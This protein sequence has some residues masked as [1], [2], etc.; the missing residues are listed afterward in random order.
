MARTAEQIAAD[1]ALTTAI[2][3]TIAAY[4]PSNDAYVLS[5]YL[6]VT[7]QQRFDEDGDGITAVGTISRD[8]NVP[9]HRLL[10]LLDYAT[11]RMR[12]AISEDDED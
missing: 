5:E 4:Y 2:E 8:G 6:V 12:K 9:A 7:C 11:T 1:D 10:G 3:Q